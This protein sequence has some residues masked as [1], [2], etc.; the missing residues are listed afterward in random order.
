MHGWETSNAVISSI[1]PQPADG[2]AGV[3]FAGGHRLRGRRLHDRS[4]AVHYLYVEES[5][6][7]KIS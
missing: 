4:R 1:S 3:H 6:P 5:E 2:W 7:A